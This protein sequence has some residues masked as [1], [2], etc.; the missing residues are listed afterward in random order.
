MVNSVCRPEAEAAVRLLRS[1]FAGFLHVVTVPPKDRKLA[2][3]LTAEGVLLKPD[4]MRPDYRMAS[5]LIDGL[6]RTRVIPFVYPNAPT[7]PPIGIDTDAL[8]VLDTLIESIK[9]RKDVIR[10]A[11]DRSYKTSNVPVGGR[12]RRRVPRESVYDTELTRV[13]ASW[14]RGLRDWTVTGQWHLRTKHKYTD[15]TLEQR[16]N[17]PIVLELLA[18]GDPVSVRSH[19]EKTPEH[20]NFLSSNEGWIVHFTCEDNYNPV[21]QSDVELAGEGCKCCAFCT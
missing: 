18:T 20:L 19:I 12:S 8:R 16:G 10:S 9:S 15:I 11:F 4:V 1:D 5:P 6:I 3:F 7:I 17:P 21:W 2:D 14:L 13:L